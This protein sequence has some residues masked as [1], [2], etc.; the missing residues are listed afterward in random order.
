M[1]EPFLIAHKVRGE[2]A[3]DIAERCMIGDEE[4]WIISTSGHRAYPYWTHSLNGLCEEF[5]ISDM[6]E[7]MPEGHPDHYPTNPTKPPPRTGG[8]LLARLGLV[9][10]PEPIKRRL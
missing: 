5:I 9:V 3:F 8:N 7:D 10:K 2:S 6:L 1:G 4:A